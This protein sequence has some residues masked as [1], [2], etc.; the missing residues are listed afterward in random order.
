[1]ITRKKVKIDEIMDSDIKKSIDIWKIPGRESVFYISKMAVDADGSP[2]AYHPLNSPGLD[3]VFLDGEGGIAK[4]KVD[5]VKE[6]CIQ[7]LCDP[8]PGYYVSQTALNDYYKEAWDTSKYVNAEE[9]PYIVIPANK[10]GWGIKLGDLGVVIN[11]R[12]MSGAYV[13]VADTG[14]QTRLAKVPLH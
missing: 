7:G 9:I 14:R 10:P 11:L 6:F 5:D 1:M 3:D 13:I 2:R 4:I 8:C 12:N